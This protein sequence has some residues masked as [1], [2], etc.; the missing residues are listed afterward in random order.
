[1]AGTQ[2]KVTNRVA[3]PT[4]LE[5]SLLLAKIEANVGR[6][7]T[8]FEIGRPVIQIVLLEMLDATLP[9]R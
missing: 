4:Q 8:I 1:M 2:M 5:R 9:S 6:V 7:G 3:F